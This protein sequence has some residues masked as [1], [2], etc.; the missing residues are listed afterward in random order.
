[1]GV[2]R[3]VIFDES[4]FWYA[5]DVT[6]SEPIEEEVD[7][8]SEDDILPSLIPKE[9]AIS[10]MLCGLQEPSSNQSTFWTSAALNRRKAKMRDYEVD[11]SNGSDANG[12]TYYADSDFGVPIM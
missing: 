2:S 5:S 12:L 10:T 1:M 6:P 9:N 8:H 4:M 7:I 3:D 11:H